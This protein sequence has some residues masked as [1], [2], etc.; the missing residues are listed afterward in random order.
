M[1]LVKRL[2]IGFALLLAFI[3]PA[4]AK[5]ITSDNLYLIYEADDVFMEVFC[6]GTQLKVKFY[7]EPGSE[8]VAY[9]S[10]EGKTAVLRINDDDDFNV[11]LTFGKLQRDLVETIKVKGN[12]GLEGVLD[13]T[14]KAHHGHV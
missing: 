11:T 12:K 14:Y 4:F 7:D 3:V 10:I 13:G 5:G 1:L 2:F 6:D 8:I 9:G